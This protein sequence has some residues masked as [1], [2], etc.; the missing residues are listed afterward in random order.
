MSAIVSII[1]P[2]YNVEPYLTQCL[3]SILEQNLNEWEC[4]LVNDGSTDRSGAICD[5]YSIKDERFRVIHKSNGG[6]SSAR[7]V[8]L[9]MSRGEWIC[10]V[11]SDDRLTSDALSYMLKITEKTNADVCLC[12][13]IGD[14]TFLPETNILT[15]TE[16][17]ELIWSCLAYRTDNYVSRGFLIDAPH[18]KLFRA[19][20]IKENKLQ[21]IDGLCK[22]EDALFDAE[23]YHHSGR[24]VMDAYPVYHYNTQNPNSICRTYK[25]ENIPMF[26]ILLRHE[27]EFVEKWYSDSSL[28]RNVLKIRTYVA[29][30]QVL[31]ETGVNNLSLSDRMRALRLF[32][33]SKTI[34]S[35]IS[36]TRYSDIST[37][38]S[39][40]SRRLDL[41]LIKNRLY[42]VLCLWVSMC[43][44]VLSLRVSFVSCIKRLFH[45]KPNVSLSSLFEN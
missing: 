12:P 14:R 23:F 43:K 45:I 21:Y 27:R 41:I 35:I 16:K 42:A 19:S 44:M 34:R 26:G 24:I 25:F 9:A 39:G 10:F 37:Y 28:F 22:S 36:N 30:E 4:I 15:E 31:Y 2:V 5:D 8:G 29:L 7:N 17:N 3:D 20:V 6:V 13:I 38:I 11:D 18:A 40:R 1:V 32:M 33:E